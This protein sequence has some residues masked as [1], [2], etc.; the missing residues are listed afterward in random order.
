MRSAGS[1]NRVGDAVSAGYVI[2]L[3]KYRVEQANPMIDATTFDGIFLLESQ[4]R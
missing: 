1:R 2:L 3:N 4:S